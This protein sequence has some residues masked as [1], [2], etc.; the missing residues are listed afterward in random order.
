MSPRAVVVAHGE[1]MVAE[2]IAAALARFPSIVPIGI[3][4]TAADGERRGERADAVV[5]DQGLPGAD[6]AA[7]RL[8][9]KGVRVVLMGGT[10][11]EDE[12]VRVTTREPVAS[13]AAALAPN[14]PFTPRT[15]ELTARERQVMALVA[16]GMPAKQVARHLGISPR[17]VEHHQERV[18]R[19]LGAPN[20]AAAV[21]MVT[22][23][24][25]EM[26]AW[27]PTSI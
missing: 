16:H 22:E 20:Q 12:G 19:K 3:A 5:L 14:V 17:T 11:D 10:P 27:V 15:V 1:V 18:R 8:R 13:L 6:A 9:R 23:S 4:T 26:E 24:I 7:G 25:G 2:G 21:R